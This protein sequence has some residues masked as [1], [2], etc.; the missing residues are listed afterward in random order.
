MTLYFLTGNKNKFAEVKAVLPQV[1]QLE[2]D[3]PEIQELDAHKI[4]SAKLKEALKHHTGPLMAEDTSLY[5]DGMNGLPGPFCK[6]FLHALGDK[7]SIEFFE[8]ETRGTIVEPKTESKFGWDAIFLPNGSTKTYNEMS[9]EEKNAISHR[10][11]ALAKLKA[12]LAR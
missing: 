4:V 7:G 11:K 5:I 9:R 10:G 1:E 6:W 2:V 8:G 12:H 3:L